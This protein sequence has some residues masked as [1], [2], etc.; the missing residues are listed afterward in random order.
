SLVLLVLA[1]LVVWHPTLAQSLVDVRKLCPSTNP[2][3]LP[4]EAT[5]IEVDS[6][7]H[8]ITKERSEAINCL[9]IVGTTHEYYV[10]LVGSNLSNVLTQHGGYQAFNDPFV[11]RPTEYEP[12]VLYV[13]PNRNKYEVKVMKEKKRI[14]MVVDNLVTW[15][16]ASLPTKRTDPEK[17]LQS[18]ALLFQA[19]DKGNLVELSF[20]D[21]EPDGPPILFR[22]A[23]STLP[24][25]SEI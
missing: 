23:E 19:R 12:T 22:F 6:T 2:Q 3:I 5:K 24:G 10:D 7:L 18:V 1:G 17:N 21:Q 14:G 4:F 13:R 16:L 11:V 8:Q 20:V 25:I 9:Q 15:L